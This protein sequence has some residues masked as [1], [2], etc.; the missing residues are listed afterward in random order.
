MEGIVQ[1][2]IMNRVVSYSLV[3]GQVLTLIVSYVS[4]KVSRC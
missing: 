1:K 3:F 4:S 2:K